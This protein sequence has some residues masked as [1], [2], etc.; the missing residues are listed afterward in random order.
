MLFEPLF[1]HARNHPQD[2]AMTDDFGQWN[3]Q[4]V[5]AMAAGIGMYLA[6]Q[7]QKPHV[8]ILLPP[9]AG[10]AASFFG[11]LLAGKSIVPINYLL[12]DREIAH[13]IAD[14]GIDTVITIPQLA[15]RLKDHPLKVVDLLQLAQT[16]P[17]A[18]T[19]KF[20]SP[21]ADDLAVL[22]YTSGTSGLPKGVM[23][24]YGN[25]QS[26]VDA[27]IEHAI[28][29]TKHVFLGVIPLFHA[30][31]V[32]AMLLAPVQLKAPVVYTA[33]FS[34]VGTIQAIRKHKA[35]I[36]FGV[37][38]MYAAIL[39]LES[40]KPDEF[41][42][43]FALISGAEPLPATVREGFE[44]RFGTRIHE[45]YGLTET[46][47]VV[48]LNTPMQNK[49]GSVG[50]CVPGAEVRIVDDEGKT[51]GRETTG[52]IWLKG[53]MVMKGY[54]NLPKETADVL[55]ADGYFKTGDLGKIDSEGFLFITGR[56]KELIISAGEKIVPR[57]V[58]DVLA[59]HPQVVEVAVVGKKDAS[60]GEVVIA[61]VVPKEPTLKADELRSF[62]RDQG[63]VQFKVPREIVL[64]PEL[65][66]SPTGKVLKRVLAEKANA[67]AG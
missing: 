59:R 47:P 44:R 52:E 46:S 31:G 34:P 62:C 3:Y 10:F 8:G 23:L 54:Y 57:E 58:E 66:R 64:V 37:P 21:K 51:V 14:S 9:S 17:A 18:I 13:C 29:Q 27:A 45:G 4:Q 12:G 49:A 41:K 61:F 32:T 28:L 16:P 42:E 43:M 35:S 7:T 26:N 1:M 63:L 22:M 2:L 38:A 65:P 39:R 5:A 50:K 67:S 6:S 48:T 33:R 19:P 11:T 25:L 24:T 60:R 36:M 40:A 30:F 56:K 20:P 53:P 55:T 15:G